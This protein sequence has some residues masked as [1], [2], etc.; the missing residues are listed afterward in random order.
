[1][2]KLL[3]ITP[4]EWPSI[5]KFRFWLESGA[6]NRPRAFTYHYGFLARDRGQLVDAFTG[7]VLGGVKWVSCPEIEEL[8]GLAWSAYER[9]E[10]VLAQR[11]RGDMWYEYLAIRRA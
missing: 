7:S 4:A 8:A 5:G 6:T 3:E 1:M 11:R 2:S 9:G 10:V